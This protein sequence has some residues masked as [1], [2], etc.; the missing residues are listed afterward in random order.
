MSIRLGGG[1]CRALLRVLR[2]T[3]IPKPYWGYDDLGIFFLVVV[4]LGPLLN[5]SVRLRFVPN[6]ENSSPSL[7][8]GIVILLSVALYL[9]LEIRYRRPVLRPLG[10]RFPTILGA[11]AAVGCGIGAGTTVSLCLGI[12]GQ[13]ISQT[14]S[15]ELLVVVLFLGPALEESVFRGFIL[16]LLAQTCGSVSGVATTALLFAVLHGPGTVGQW[17]S[18][19]MMGIVYGYVRVASGSTFTSAIVHSTYNVSLFLWSAVAPWS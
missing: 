5:L 6:A 15:S 9:V 2:G 10:W 19:T 12:S 18:I 7:Q 16:P 11:L 14:F 17:F 3:R 13:G 8:M 4:L 1:R